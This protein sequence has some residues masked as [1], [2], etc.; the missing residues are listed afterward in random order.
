MMYFVQNQMGKLV[1]FVEYEQV[2]EC[3]E[4]QSCLCHMGRDN[5]MQ[6]DFM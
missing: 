5:G 6:C 1:G 4:C 2:Y 3:C